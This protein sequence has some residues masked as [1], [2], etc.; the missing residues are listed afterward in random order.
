M[1]FPRDCLSC[2]ARS[3]RCLAAGEL[4]PPSATDDNVVSVTADD[5]VVV[6]ATAQRIDATQTLQRVNSCAATDRATRRP[7][8]AKWSRRPAAASSMSALQPRVHPDR[9]GFLEAQG[10]PARSRQAHY[11]RPL[12]RHWPHPRPVLARRMLPL[13]HRLR[14]RCRR[15]EN[16]SRRSARRRWR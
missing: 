8:Y 6:R 11:R 9:A 5:A 4:I 10:S 3:D 14:L 12:E 15:M 1:G 2:G 13:L 16:R 7:P